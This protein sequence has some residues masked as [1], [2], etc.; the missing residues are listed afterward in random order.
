VIGRMIATRIDRWQERAR[1][2]ATES[3]T[4]EPGDDTDPS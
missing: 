4:E 1:Q 3:A 2:P